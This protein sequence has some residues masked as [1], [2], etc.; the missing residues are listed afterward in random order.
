MELDYSTYM[1]ELIESCSTAHSPG[2]S[3]KE[4]HPVHKMVHQRLAFAAKVDRNDRGNILIFSFPSR[5]PVKRRRS[6]VIL[7]PTAV[8]ILELRASL[9]DIWCG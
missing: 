2:S 4:G 9:R 5:C 3:D 7:G 6:E 8:Q 1:T